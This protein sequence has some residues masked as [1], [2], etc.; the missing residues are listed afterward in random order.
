MAESSDHRDAKNKASDTPKHSVRNHDEK[1]IL[2]LPSYCT[3]VR[4]R[5][6][7]DA[8]KSLS[9]IHDSPPLLPSV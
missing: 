2:R 7:S 1:P 5:P 9:V 4:F 6:D 8:A 3:V